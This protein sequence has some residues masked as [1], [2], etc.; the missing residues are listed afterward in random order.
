MAAKVE[1]KR[2]VDFVKSAEVSPVPDVTAN[3]DAISQKL[4]WFVLPCE[5][6][7]QMRGEINQLAISTGP[8]SPWKPGTMD[9]CTNAAAFATSQK[10]SP[11]HRPNT[12]TAASPTNHQAA[13]SS[14]HATH[15]RSLVGSTS[16][17]HRNRRPTSSSPQHLFSLARPM[18]PNFSTLHNEPKSHAKHKNNFQQENNS[19]ANDRSTTKNTYLT[20][21]STSP[22]SAAE[23]LN[24]GDP[25]E[26]EVVLK[27]SKGPKVL[28]SFTKVSVSNER[29][30]RTSWQR[31]FKQLYRAFI[32]VIK[33]FDI[34]HL[35]DRVLVC[36][37][38][39]KDSL[40]LL[41]CMHAYQEACLRCP[42]YPFFEIGAVTVDP[43]SSAFD[44]RP[45]IP[46]LAELVVKYFFERQSR[47]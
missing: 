9:P 23:W 39:G 31:P 8:S 29:V 27:G 22:D 36:L 2:A 38:G 17:R 24:S 42:D 13:K 44:P 34:I 16:P 30:E 4:R 1:L 25:N 5:A 32:K 35:G 20:L 47:P 37:S 21:K 33:Y 7:A 41:H 14:S 18:S 43:G 11:S 12:A 3:F 46:Y 6:A 28:S 45:P 19:H 10:I 15:H 26:L 40:S